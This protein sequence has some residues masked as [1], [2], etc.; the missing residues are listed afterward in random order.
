MKVFMN[1]VKLK[2]DPNLSIK[3][4]A[5]MCGVSESAVRKYIRTNGIDRNYDNKVV[6]KRAIL[7]L[8]KENSTMSLTEMSRRLG[9]SVN[10][11]KKYLSLDDNQSDINTSK[12]STFDL[13]KRN[14]VIKSVSDDQ[15]EI[16]LNILR[17]HIHKETFDC[18]LTYSKGV[19]YQHIPQPK[20]KFDKYPLKEDIMPLEKAKDIEDASLHSIVI[21]LPFIVKDYNS[22][23]TSM[24]AQRF[25]YFSSIDELYATNASMISLA[26]R[27][28]RK[29]GFL[30][31]KTM[32]FVYGINQYWVSNFV[33]NTAKEIGFVLY[34]TFILISKTK[35]LTTKGEKQHFAR[36]FHSYFFVF[37]KG[38]AHK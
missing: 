15:T 9:Y 6:K 29:S 1:K 37:H 25:N 3:K 18:D 22:A 26:F 13:S 16:L 4:N 35:I 31:M 21:D 23:Q 19:F 10:T 27:K 38:K 24:I 11:I 2:Y 36:K 7:A 28:L 32:D 34:D 30:V 17:L 12:V 33:H 8:R 20:L 14:F 5:A